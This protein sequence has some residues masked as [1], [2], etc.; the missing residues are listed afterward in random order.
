M[1][2]RLLDVSDLAY[3]QSSTNP[4]QPHVVARVWVVSYFGLLW[5]YLLCIDST[6]VEDYW[7]QERGPICLRAM[8][9]R[10]GIG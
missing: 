6:L 1:E 9:Y 7:M 2:D 4:S 5:E 10:M 8:G 3:F